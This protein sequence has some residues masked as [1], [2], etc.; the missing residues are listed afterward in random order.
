MR[1]PNPID[2]DVGDKVRQL[3]LLLGLTQLVVGEAIGVSFQQIQKYEAGTNRISASRLQ[4]F[5]DFLQVPTSYFFRSER[6]GP[7][8]IS[9]EIIELDR[10]FLAL[11]DDKTRKIIL[12]LVLS[13]V[14]K[15]RR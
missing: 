8:G 10:A 5:A 2:I 9:S 1:P 4:Q 3:R 13:L 6:E 15:V 14:D 11:S 7:V 12:D